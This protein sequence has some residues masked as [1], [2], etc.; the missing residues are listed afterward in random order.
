MFFHACRISF[1]ADTPSPLAT[2]TREPPLSDTDI[3]SPPEDSAGITGD[4]TVGEMLSVRP[5]NE[6]MQEQQGSDILDKSQEA[7]SVRGA[8]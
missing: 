6:V 5:R 2:P 8:L 3:S 1:G 7:C 4:L